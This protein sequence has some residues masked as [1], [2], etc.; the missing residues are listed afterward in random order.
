MR[1]PLLLLAAMACE[2]AKPSD[3]AAPGT[4][5]TGTTDDLQTRD[6]DGDGHPDVA[7][8][9]PAD[10]T[11]YP[12]APETCNR[13]D[14]DCDGT[15]DNSPVDPITVYTDHDGDG[16]GDPTT[17][18]AAC[19]ASIG[20]STRADDCDDTD[21]LVHP[22]A[23][24]VCWSGKDEDCD[25]DPGFCGPTGTLTPGA[26]TARWSGAAGDLLGTRVV[27]SAHPSGEGPAVLVAG[28]PGAR[29]G[30]GGVMVLDTPLAGGGVVEPT[31]G[32]SG[33][34]RLGT[35]LF[36]P[37]D[38]DGDGFPDLL[39][40]ATG[41]HGARGTVQLF[42]GGVDGWDT[43]RA[44]V[45]GGSVGDGAGHVVSAGDT[46]GD[47][48][49]DLAVGI[50]GEISGGLRGAVAVVSGPLSSMDPH[51]SSATA[52]VRGDTP[53]GRTGYSLA[54]DHDLDGDGLA[55][56]VVGAPREGAGRFAIFLG[57]VSGT[58]TLAD[59]DHRY[60]S[61]G[62]AFELGQDVAWLGD[63]DGDGAP[64][65]AVSAPGGS[66]NGA[67]LVFYGADIQA[68]GAVLDSAAV[69][70]A[71]LGTQYSAGGVAPIG[72]VNG[73]GLPDVHAG[74]PGIHWSP[75]AGGID[76]DEA[77]LWLTAETTADG[78]DV[79]GWLPAHLGPGAHPDLDE[80]GYAEV[81]FAGPG[82]A[83]SGRTAAGELQV[84]SPAGF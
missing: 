60:D 63:T 33:V 27:W 19:Q 68:A 55:D 3:S 78:R 32:G 43:V 56:L 77:D 29:A 36:A 64:D 13:I 2:D 73:D 38:V 70:A 25:G 62:T 26:L 34:D 39:V 10:P 16:F 44:V 5:T 22:D 40:G 11:V 49:V 23:T 50:P 59:A 53:G 66:L 20:E 46:N 83:P 61:D 30:A 51:L 67:V 42:A 6:S 37:G 52:T 65:L 17:A 24:E 75:L 14:D 35:G 79:P 69:G 57:P 41:A 21:P 8:C 76:A 28:A 81:I 18:T 47:G 84:L 74:G 72:D 45:S 15:P 82:L 80:D 12:G 58:T 9:G 71:V 1:A 31:I 54:M 7:D 48:S 4:T